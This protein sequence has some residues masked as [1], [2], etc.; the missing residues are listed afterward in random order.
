[1]KVPPQNK[2]N[3]DEFVSVIRNY[4]SS[5]LNRN[6]YFMSITAGFDSYARVMTL[7]ETHIA[8][9]GSGIGGL[10]FAH[11]AYLCGFRVTVIEQAEILSEIGSGISIWENGLEA[12]EAIGL[13]AEVE[14][15]GLAWP[16]YEMH[17]AGKSPIMRNNQILSR[18]G[19]VSPLIIKRGELFGA[20]K[21]KLSQ[22]INIFTSF[23]LDHIEGH[24]LRAQDGREIEADIIIGADGAHSRVRQELTDRV[25]RFCNQICFRGI[26]PPQNGSPIRGAEVYDK[27][28]HRFGYFPLPDNEVYWFDIVDSEIPRQSFEDFQTEIGGLSPRIAQLIHDTPDASILCHPIEEMK[29][30]IA[31]HNHIALIGDAA[32]PMQ[33][34]LGQGACLA[35]EDAIVLADCLKRHAPDYPKAIRAYIST[36]K[37]RWNSY[38]KMCRQ[39]G[40][41]ALDKGDFGRKL[42]IAR[43]AHTPNWA[44][45]LFGRKI[46]AFKQNDIR[47]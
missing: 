31:A 46:F 20:L 26:S 25:P 36:R 42:A 28:R 5:D 21:D 7:S 35:L 47:F 13:R 22:Y 6:R 2:A 9:V 11:A 45:S 33:P 23:K 37:G 27:H 30:V 29:P 24:T 16:H 44:L 10:A 41:G 12:L 40:T 18:R 14:T 17:R 15:R 19:N 3:N 39:L 32:H 4:L 34:S 1:M 43:M 8:I 38:Y